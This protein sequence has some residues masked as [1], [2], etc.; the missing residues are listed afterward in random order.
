M[1]AAIDVLK[2]SGHSGASARAIADKAGC[3]QALVFYYFGSVAKLLLAALDEVSAQ[4]FARYTSVVDS[5]SSAHDLV[6]AAVK[7][8]REDLEE[9][10]VR[11]L[12]ESIAAAS[13]IPGFGAEVLER[14]K[15]WEA[16][17]RQTLSRLF[18]GSPFQ[19]LAGSDLAGRMVAATFLG[20]EML[21]HLEEG[22]PKAQALATQ[23][24]DLLSAAPSLVPTI[25]RSDLVKRS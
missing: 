17:A 4:R 9:G 1:D 19:S 8:F 7:I 2:K 14:I 11:V 18:E 21:A 3:N 15:P 23:I 5:A 10:Y 12:V 24:G 13:S 6:D 20:L 22:D 25:G 16:F